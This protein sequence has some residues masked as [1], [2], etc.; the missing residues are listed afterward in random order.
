M[1][2]ASR[3]FAVNPPLDVEGTVN[4]RTPAG[5]PARYGTVRE[6]ALYRSDGLD[7]VSERGRAAIARLGLS[8]IVDLRAST[9]VD[10]SPSL[11]P[12]HIETVQVELY[13]QASALD[14]AAPRPLGEMYQIIM[15]TRLPQIARAVQLVAD[16]P[17]GAVLVHCTA[18]KDRTGLVVATVLE[19]VGVAR[20]HV[21][22]DYAASAGN[23]AG[24]WLDRIVALYEERNG[25]AAS[26][27]FM[28]LA[29]TS[30]A[31]VL[32]AVLDTVDETW[33]GVTPM[34]RAH[35]VDDRVL[36][37]LHERLVGQG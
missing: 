23:L 13:G 30:P 18:G 3:S 1:S 22:D 2:T 21:L 10:R 7:R 37:L 35:G 14:G 12:S 20:E 34:L 17:A 25:H 16:A 31:E 36:D 15:R 26:D 28:H 6:G 5:Y 8:R 32:G 9:E 24:P 27:E 4:F 11:V 29:A 19:A 33:G